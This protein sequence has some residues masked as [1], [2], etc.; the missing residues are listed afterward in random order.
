M[1]QNSRKTVFFYAAFCFLGAIWAPPNQPQKFLKDLKGGRMYGP[2][3]TLKDKPLI[4]ALGA[5]L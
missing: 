1:V 2:M 4:K 5:F 3:C